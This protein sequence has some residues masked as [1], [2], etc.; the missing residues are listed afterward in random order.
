MTA[1]RQRKVLSSKL[2]VLDLS[3]RVRISAAMTGIYH[4]IAEIHV[5][6]V[7]P[8]ENNRFSALIGP[9]RYARLDGHMHTRLSQELPIR[10]YC[11]NRNA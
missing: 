10:K 4:F 3:A 7:T 9:P 5:V 6:G 8:R 1:R 11:S 2:L